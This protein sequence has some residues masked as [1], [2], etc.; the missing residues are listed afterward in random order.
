LERNQFTIRIPGL[1][2]LLL[3][4]QLF[5]LIL[6]GLVARSVIVQPRPHLI[7]G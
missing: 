4:D 1:L 7:A 3:Y 5:L 6:L 2:M